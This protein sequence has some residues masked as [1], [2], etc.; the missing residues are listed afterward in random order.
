M[1]KCAKIASAFSRDGA[2]GLSTKQLATSFRERDMFRWLKLPFQAYICQLPMLTVPKANGSEKQTMCLETVSIVDILAQIYSRDLL[3]ECLMNTETTLEEWWRNETDPQV[4]CA[5]PGWTFPIIV[6]EDAVPNWHDTSATFW[7]WC[8]PLCLG[9]SW[10]SRNCI[11]GLPSNRIC[12]QTRES[13][14]RVVAWDLK[15][16]ARGVWPA[17]DHLGSAF[18]DSSVRG[19]RAGSAIMGPFKACFSWWKG[20]MEAHVHSHQQQ[21]SYT[22]NTI[23]DH[24]WA[25]KNDLALCAGDFTQSAGWRLTVEKPGDGGPP[26]ESP[27]L[28]VP[29]FSKHRKLY[30]R[31]LAHLLFQFFIMGMVFY[32]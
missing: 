32:L 10:T 16:L 11:V 5:E 29:N 4:A 17:E 9:G 31:V 24:C 21:R 23:C 2:A 13:I 7:S 26:G 14:A 12:R 1:Q 28:A 19:R 3:E 25:M 15:A 30:D 8:S 6:H 20:D 22:K 27:W 18:D